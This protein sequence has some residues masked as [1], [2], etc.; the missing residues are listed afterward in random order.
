MSLLRAVLQ[1]DMASRL[2]PPEALER[3]QEYAAALGRLLPGPDTIGFPPMLGPPQDGMHEA[4]F[5]AAGYLQT[6]SGSLWS[7]V[8]HVVSFLPFREVKRQHQAKLQQQFSAGAYGHRGFV[9]LCKQTEQFGSVLRLLN[10]L[11]CS[12]HSGHAW[13]TVVI[14]VNNVARG[15]AECTLL[16]LGDRLVSSLPRAYVDT[17]LQ[18]DALDGAWP[19]SGCGR[20]QA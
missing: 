19:S 16:Q 5:T 7:A 9:G 14:T 13:T 20:A 3:F 4:E 15:Q 12:L 2:L 10:M 11:V 8:R 17:T 1:F 18:G 6:G